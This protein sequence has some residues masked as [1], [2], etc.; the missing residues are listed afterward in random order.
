MLAQSAMSVIPTL[1][2]LFASGGV[3]L[4]A[5]GVVVTLWGVY[6][7]LKP[8]RIGPILSQL[9]FTALV[10]VAAMIGVYSSAAE[11]I[12]LAAAETAPKP[13]ELSAAAGRAMSY[14]FVGLMATT[15]PVFLQTIAIRRHSVILRLNQTSTESQ[16]NTKN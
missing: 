12:E 2:F 10:G 3:V 1:R 11:F 7:I 16:V 9:V 5:C 13:A 6:S 4:L 14:G 8:E 15:I